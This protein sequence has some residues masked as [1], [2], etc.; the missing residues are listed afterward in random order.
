MIAMILVL[1]LI[2]GLLCAPAYLA[3][4]RKGG[5][6]RWFLVS[7]LPA[8]AIWIGMTVL[9]Y[10]AQS[11]ANI[12]EVFWIVLAT[13]ALSYLKVFLVDRSI[14]K[15]RQTTY[16]LIVFLIIAVVLLRTFMPSLPE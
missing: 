10:G 12:I 7:A 16:A 15:P 14:H 4:Q 9:G 2:V 13:I 11:L 3:S 5:E 6:S 1:V 8:I